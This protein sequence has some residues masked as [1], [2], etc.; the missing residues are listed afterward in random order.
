MNCYSVGQR[1]RAT[2]P[3]CHSEA[4]PKNLVIAACWIKVKLINNNQP[5]VGSDKP[6]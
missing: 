1:V 5:K 4:R 2:V 6:I 3:L